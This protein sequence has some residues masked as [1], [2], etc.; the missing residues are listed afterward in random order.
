MKMS[1]PAAPSNTV[2]NSESCSVYRRGYVDMQDSLQSE[3]RLLDFGCF[4]KTFFANMIRG[5]PRMVFFPVVGQL[6]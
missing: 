3:E 6:C 5:R 1:T 2:V 4:Q